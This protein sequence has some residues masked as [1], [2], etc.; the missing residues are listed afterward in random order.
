MVLHFADVGFV[1][2]EGSGFWD[3]SRAIWFTEPLSPP[4]QIVGGVLGW[5]AWKERAMMAGGEHGLQA[6]DVSASWID[7]HGHVLEFPI[8]FLYF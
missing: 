3:R 1:V 2:D 7:D 5:G 6:S 8:R 4:F